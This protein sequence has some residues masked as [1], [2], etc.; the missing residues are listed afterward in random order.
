M[1]TATPPES[2]LNRALAFERAMHAAAAQRTVTAPWGQAYF[3]PAI[4]LVYDRNLLRLIG[5]AAGLDAAAADAHAERL[6]AAAGVGHRRILAEPATGEHLEPGLRALG[7]DAD[8][9]VVMVHGGT[10]ARPPLSAVPVVEIEVDDALASMDHQLS[11]D[12]SSLGGRDPGVR[13]Q[14]LE[15]ARG[16]GRAGAVERCH[17]VI[18]QQGEVAAWA[19]RWTRGDVTQIEDVACLPE[20]R[21]RGYG[22]AVVSHAT[23]AA[24]DGGSTLLFI[25]A[26]ADDWPRELYARLGYAVA[27]AKRLFTRHAPGFAWGAPSDS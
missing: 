13:A 9:H 18:G 3:T 26:E 25:N 19:L 11:T 21:G 16:F 2:P 4:G 5:D 6:H 14:L 23:H 22:R 15:H 1:A 12:P 17:A 7:Y 27:G 24:L 10:T 8:E 20:H